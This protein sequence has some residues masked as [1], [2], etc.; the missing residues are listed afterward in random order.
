MRENKNKR[1][2]IR[3]TEEL[4]AEVEAAARRVR[5]DVAEYVR[6]AVEEKMKK[7]KKEVDR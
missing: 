7:D 4:K 5:M 3:V 1:I 2:H 6:A